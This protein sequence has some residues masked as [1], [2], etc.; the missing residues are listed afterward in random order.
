MRKIISLHP[1]MDIDM[2]GET[3]SSLGMEERVLG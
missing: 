2:A 1:C 3:E